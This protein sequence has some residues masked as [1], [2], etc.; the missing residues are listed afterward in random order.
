MKLNYQDHWKKRCRLQEKAGMNR[1]QRVSNRGQVRY[2][3]LLHTA[4]S[5]DF[6]QVT[7]GSGGEKAGDTVHQIL[8][9]E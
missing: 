8:C 2:K 4:A 6:R 5:G 9:E 3:T 7:G 1:S